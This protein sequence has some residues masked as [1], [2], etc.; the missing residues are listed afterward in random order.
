MGLKIAS[1]YTLV[2]ENANSVLPET[3]D[4]IIPLP[5]NFFALMKGNF[6]KIFSDGNI[7]HTIC[8]K[9]T[10]NLIIHRKPDFICIN[11]NGKW[12]FLLKNGAISSTEFDKVNAQMGNDKLIGVKADGKWGYADSTGTIC[13]P[14]RYEYAPYFSHS[15]DLPVLVKIDGKYTFYDTIRTGTKFDLFDNATPFK[16]APDLR[17]NVA[18]VS[19][20]KK[21][22]L[23]LPNGN[24][25]FEEF[26]DSFHVVE[27]LGIRVLR[28]DYYDWYNLE[29]K[30]ILS[31]YLSISP[32]KDLPL[33]IVKTE[34]GYGIV[35]ELGIPITKFVYEHKMLLTEKMFILRKD[36]EF[37][38]FK[39]DTGEIFT[40]KTCCE[41]QSE[42]D[43]A[44]VALNYY[45]S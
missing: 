21:V 45:L 35:D 15:A 42:L 23:L 38:L 7:L 31:N 11:I 28:G 12:R 41:N 2:N 26:V 43:F 6:C 8:V 18:Y 24:L 33:F 32:Q 20:G 37:T 30:I 5:N 22:N 40:P 13:I 9:E 1:C 39:R 4:E 17:K 19:K 25:L 3:Y 10:D 16:Y 34:T 36:G 29:G 14:T 27:D 44:L